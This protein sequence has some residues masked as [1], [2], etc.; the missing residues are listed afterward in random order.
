MSEFD[1]ISAQLLSGFTDLTKEVAGLKGVILTRM[2]DTDRRVDAL[3]RGF[4]SLLDDTIAQ[5]TMTPK[6]F[7]ELARIEKACHERH[8]RLNNVL[9]LM[10]KNDSAEQLERAR[11]TGRREQ[12]ER[13]IAKCLIGLGVVW[14]LFLTAWQ[15]WPPKWWPKV[16]P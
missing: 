12:T 5:E 13:I 8:L 14:A 4:R 3:E 16:G 2:D 11:G 15:T 7:D 1:T 9:T 10:E 6:A